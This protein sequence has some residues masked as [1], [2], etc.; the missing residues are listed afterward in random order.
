MG[1]EPLLHQGILGSTL[2]A[3]HLEHIPVL[4]AHIAMGWEPSERQDGRQEAATIATII[5]TSDL[6]AIK[7]RD[8][9]WVA[10]GE[11][12]LEMGDQYQD[13]R[14]ADVR[15]MGREEVAM[16]NT[17][18]AEPLY[19]GQ[20]PGTRLAEHLYPNDSLFGDDQHYLQLPPVPPP[21]RASTSTSPFTVPGEVQGMESNMPP[22][23]PT[24]HNTT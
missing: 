18:Y 6:W 23:Q 4:L 16:Y 10:R 9:M 5:T 2:V 1:S 24:P 13:L 7:M 19:H 8:G 17:D 15:Q 3:N 11:G 20:N 22:A 21:S 14:Y 12:G